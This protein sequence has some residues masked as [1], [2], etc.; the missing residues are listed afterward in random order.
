M[1][2]A[3]SLTAFAAAPWFGTYTVGSHHVRVLQGGEGLFVELAMGDEVVKRGPLV[4]E[5][6]TRTAALD[7]CGGTFT[8]DDAHLK[9]T[10]DGP[11]CPVAMENRYVKTVVSH[12]AP[13]GAQ[14]VLGCTI[15]QKGVNKRLE[16]CKAGEGALSYRFGVLGK[17]E[18]VLENGR[19][20]ERAL[21]SGMETTWSFD[22][23]GYTYRAF[24]VE[25]SRAMDNGA[26]VVVAQGDKDLATLVCADDTWTFTP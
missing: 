18:L 26:G 23:A 6:A 5:G 25:S 24:V 9:L 16:V 1:L 12:C 21:A 2:V 19:F 8:V 14:T 11:E 7:G 17:P 13:V 20:A 3:L 10:L 15:H 4:G 22:N